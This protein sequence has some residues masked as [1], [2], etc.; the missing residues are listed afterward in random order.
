MAS[1]MMQQTVDIVVAYLKNNEMD[2]EK[3][4]LLIK[5]VFS[6]LQG[7]S[8]NDGID[9]QENGD[10]FPA[11][12]V[13]E[14]GAWIPVVP[15][16]EAVTQD[17]VVCLI[18]GKRGKSLRGHLTRSH[19][20]RLDEYLKVF[21]L[22]KDFRL[23]APSYSEKRRQLAVEAGLGDKLRGGTGSR[24]SDGEALGQELDSRK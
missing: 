5:N 15:V 10:D 22:P 6:A 14:N 1:E 13:P 11:V 12:R 4:P 17:E 9:P 20:M 16:E 3:I 2:A 8:G 7:I 23:V 24:L 21:N 19:Q 18:C